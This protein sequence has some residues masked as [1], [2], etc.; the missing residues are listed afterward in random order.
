MI[1]SKSFKEWCNDKIITFVEKK[2]PEE[3]RNE[4]GPDDLQVHGSVGFCEFWTCSQ[5]KP[6]SC[7]IDLGD[8]G[9]DA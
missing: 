4:V 9:S 1:D 2:A 8:L 6:T 5:A 3:Q 7:S